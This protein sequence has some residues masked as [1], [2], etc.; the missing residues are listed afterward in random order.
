[1]KGLLIA[2]NDRT[3]RE[4]LASIFSKDAYQIS[5]TESVVEGL[6]AI[7]DKQV[8]VIILAGEYDEQQIAKL[9]PLLKKCNR[10]LSIILVSEQS[11][12]ELLRRIRKE[13]NVPAIIYGADLDESEPLLPDRVLH[14]LHELERVVRRPARDV[15]AADEHLA[16]VVQSDFDSR[17]RA[18]DRVVDVGQADGVGAAAVEQ[19]Q[20]QVQALLVRR[21]NFN[22]R[23]R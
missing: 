20:G 10:H 18:S 2:H 1:M 8:Q 12:L 9:V 4:R 15:G 17:E 11:S 23:S 16:A 3:E 7:L 6:G 21:Y 19:P 14:R 22:F 13:G 5:T